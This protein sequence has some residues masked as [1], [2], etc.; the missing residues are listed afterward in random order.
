MIWDTFQWT[1]SPF[2]IASQDIFGI[3]EFFYN[4]P[5]HAVLLVL[6]FVF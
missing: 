5:G 3:Y 2:W 6:S 1:F 4:T